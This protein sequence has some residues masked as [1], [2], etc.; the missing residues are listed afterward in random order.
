VA[1][2][3]VGLPLLPGAGHPEPPSTVLPDRPRPSAQ[4]TGRAHLR[5]G[6]ESAPRQRIR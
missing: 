1:W 5:V 4:C 3:V 2:T 6:V